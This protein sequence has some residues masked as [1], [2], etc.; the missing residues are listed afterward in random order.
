M[1]IYKIVVQT[2]RQT[3]KST[4]CNRQWHFQIA[5]YQTDGKII[6]EKLHMQMYIYKE[7]QIGNWSHTLS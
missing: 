2:D 6:K 7:S 5:D 1:F 4:G 3:D